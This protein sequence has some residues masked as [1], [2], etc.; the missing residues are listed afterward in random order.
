MEFRII[1]SNVKT[2]LKI[3][4]VALMTAGALGCATGLLVSCKKQRASALKPIDQASF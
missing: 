3:R 2:N 1:P 4:A